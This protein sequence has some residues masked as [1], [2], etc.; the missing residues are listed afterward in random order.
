MKFNFLDIFFKKVVFIMALFFLG[1][2]Y[3]QVYNKEV[4]AKI[5]IERNSEFYNFSAIA[6]NLLPSANSLR[7][8]FMVF[9]VDSSNNSEKNTQSDRFVI[10]GNEK[11]IVSAVTVN[12]NVEGKVIIVFFIYNL[13][14]KPIGKD[15][16]VLENNGDLLEIT[17][18][19]NPNRDMTSQDQARPQDGFILNGLVVENTI[20]KAGRDFYKYFYNEYYNREIITTKNIIIDEVPARSRY[21]RISVKVEDQLVW[22]FFSQPKKEFLKQ[23]ARTALAK[24]IA[25]LQQLEKQ[26]DQLIQY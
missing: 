10:Q 11:K 25:R 23:M 7:Y 15:R 20:T 24:S 9:Q 19:D 1:N 26:N 21:T 18:M 6:E 5:K 13:D 22:Q 17:E 4:V 8:E 14:N 12:N 3:S 2:L 16:I